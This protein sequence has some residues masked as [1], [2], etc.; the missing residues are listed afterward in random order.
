MIVGKSG[1]GIEEKDA[2]DYVWGYTII[3]GKIWKVCLLRKPGKAHRS[4][5]VTAR[6][7]QR[8]HKQFFLGKSGETY[9]PMVSVHLSDSEATLIPSLN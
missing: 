8:D 4:Q 9:C 2:L 1:I 7:V 6:E 3:N 5:D